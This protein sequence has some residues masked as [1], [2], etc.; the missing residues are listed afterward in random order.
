MLR[1]PSLKPPARTWCSRSCLAGIIDSRRIPRR[2]CATAA[3]RSLPILAQVI[4]LKLPWM[5][6]Y[7][8]QVA[9][10][11]GAAAQHLGLDASDSSG[12]IAPR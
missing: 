2:R 1:L 9:Q 12:R 6:G 8:R 5:T 4:D 10:L 3:R 7:S 11:A